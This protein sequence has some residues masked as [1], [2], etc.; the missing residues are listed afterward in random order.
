MLRISDSAL[1]YDSIFRQHSPARIDIDIDK[2]KVRELFTIRSRLRCNHRTKNP[3]KH[4]PTNA[5]PAA[6]LLVCPSFKSR[7]FGLAL[8]RMILE[9]EELVNGYSFA[10]ER[11]R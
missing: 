10:P 3:P 8:M 1:K 7:P 5:V 2:G 4:I 11:C 9:E 6:P